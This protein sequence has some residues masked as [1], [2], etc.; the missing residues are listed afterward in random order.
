[1]N[2]SD[3]LIRRV[4]GEKYEKVVKNF[5]VIRIVAKG[6]FIPLVGIAFLFE[7]ESSICFRTFYGQVQRTKMRTKCGLFDT[8]CYY[9][10]TPLRLR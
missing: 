9:L 3:D 2:T 1:M 7:R 5:E 8:R 10:D 4:N 6:I